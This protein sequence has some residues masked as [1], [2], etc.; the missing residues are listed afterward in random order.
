M[1]V[2]GGPYRPYHAYFSTHLLDVPVQ[3]HGPLAVQ[4]GQ[5]RGNLPIAMGVQ[6]QYSTAKGH[7][8]NL[9]Q[10]EHHPYVVA[11]LFFC[12]KVYR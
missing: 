2:R 10:A 8:A 6:E 4:V 11:D 3:H 7:L 12:G 9:C 5:R 1:C